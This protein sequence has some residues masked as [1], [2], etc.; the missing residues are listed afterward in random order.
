MSYNQVFFLFIVYIAAAKKP[1]S[2]NN[3]FERCFVVSDIPHLLCTSVLDM[4]F[5]CLLLVL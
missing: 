2:I 4:D 5:E 1:R 3:I